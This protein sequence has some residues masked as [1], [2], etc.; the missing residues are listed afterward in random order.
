M[1]FLALSLVASIFCLGCEDTYLGSEDTNIEREDTDLNSD[2][3]FE[4]L[5]GTWIDNG[6]LQCNSLI[7]FR[8]R[9]KN[10]NL[11]QKF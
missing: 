3:D 6:S 9:G 1:I 5:K 10:W 11:W 4:F 7:L 2:P 8:K